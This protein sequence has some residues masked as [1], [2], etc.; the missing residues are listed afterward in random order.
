MWRCSLP[1]FL[2]AHYAQNF[3]SSFAASSIRIPKGYTL[4][5]FHGWFTYKSPMKRKDMINDLPKLQGI[6]FPF[7][8]Q[9]CNMVHLKMAPLGVGDTVDGSEILRLPVEVGSL[10]HDLRWVLYIPGGCFGF[11]IHQQY[12]LELSFSRFHVKLGECMWIDEIRALESWGFFQQGVDVEE[13]MIWGRKCL[14]KI[15]WMSQ[16]KQIP[17]L[18]WKQTHIKRC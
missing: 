13:W 17:L 9:G 6:M 8:L 4:E 10:P 16:K 5:D 15:H 1:A 14:W 7:H 2:S 12:L 3:R 18:F 11:L